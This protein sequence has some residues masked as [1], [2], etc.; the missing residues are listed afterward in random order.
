MSSRKVNKQL[1]IEGMSC[2][3]C[4]K[5]VSRILAAEASLENIQVDLNNGLA[6]F[7]CSTQTNIPALI[8]ELAAHDFIASEKT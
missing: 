6:T 7:S 5:K 8:Q 1:S 3:G 4:V 2:Q